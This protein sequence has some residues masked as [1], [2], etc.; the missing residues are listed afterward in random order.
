MLRKPNA[1]SHV[2]SWHAY[3]RY[4]LYMYVARINLLHRRA[5]VIHLHCMHDDQP[6]P[7][8]RP[9]SGSSYSAFGSLTEGSDGKAQMKCQDGAKAFQK[10]LS[11]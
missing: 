11:S 7:E 2:Y 6:L 4:V 1:V 9:L 3:A 5:H 10:F 8:D